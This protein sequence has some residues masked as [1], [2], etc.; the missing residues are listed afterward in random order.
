MENTT[1]SSRMEF[2]RGTALASVLRR[3]EVTSTIIGASR[4]EQIEEN[5]VAAD[6]TLQ[7]DTLEQIDQAVG[8]VVVWS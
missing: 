6:V 5:I 8:K 7:Q 3:R 4:P 1:R 2:R